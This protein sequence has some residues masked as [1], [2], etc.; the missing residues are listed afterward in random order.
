MNQSTHCWHTSNS[1]GITI[2][3][4]LALSKARESGYL[5]FWRVDQWWRHVIEIV[6]GVGLLLMLDISFVL[7]MSVIDIKSCTI[8]F[9]WLDQVL[10]DQFVHIILGFLFLVSVRVQSL[11]LRRSQII[12][13]FDSITKPTHC[14]WLFFFVKLCLGIPTF[15]LLRIHSHIQY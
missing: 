2:W 8:R 3:D 4:R 7:M 10:F 11:V 6:A 9:T 12:L 1:S 15:V 5:T 14:S 13:C